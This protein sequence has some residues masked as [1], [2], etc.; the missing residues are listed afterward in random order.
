MAQPQ[1]PR[2]ALP[3]FK[4]DVS[5]GGPGLITLEACPGKEADAEA[6]LKSAQALAQDE[7]AGLK[8]YAVEL[9]AGE[10][11]HLRYLCK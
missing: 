6:F 4:A 1:A 10:V 7:K 2:L 9:G 3:F 11:R 5:G 8:W